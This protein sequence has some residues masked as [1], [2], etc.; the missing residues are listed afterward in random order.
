MGSAAARF[1]AE[2]GHDVVG[3]EQ[4]AVGHDR[5]SSHGESRIFRLAY[6]DPLHAGLM[7]AALPLWER[8]QQEAGE[9]LLVRCGGLYLGPPDHAEMRD[10]AAGFAAAGSAHE[11]LGPREAAL[12][13]PALRLEPGE[14]ALWNADAGFLRPTRCVAANARIARARGA[15][16]LEGCR[17]EGLEQRRD[18][19]RIATGEGKQDF[20]RAV[21]TAGPWL[22]GLVPRVSTSRPLAVTRQQVVYLR[23]REGSELFDPSRMPIW[24]DA[25]T[26]DYGFPSDGR[27]SG[28]KV[29]SHVP[30]EAFDPARADR[31][32]D[33]ERERGLIE[34]VTRRLPA[35]SGDVLS[36]SV[37]LYTST[38][39]E[40]FV[41]DRAP[42]MD[43][44]SFVSACS[45]HG[46]KFTVLMGRIAARIAC[47]E[48]PGVDI[49]R[50]RL[51]RAP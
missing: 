30:G 41:V 38:P 48:D 22:P 5:G 40:D 21:I 46:F 39:D 7:R 47:D 32:V 33:L 18:S 44:V 10:V 43:R 42:G 45:G 31:P 8:L 4:H 17:V 24:I 20:D 28:V 34:R 36:S 6:R 9:E 2:A 12:R 25:V 23:I 51:P 50:F 3:F 27:T 15:T 35:L 37:C 11:A 13:F 29:A 1:L 14:V 26:H 49:S 19:V 16:I